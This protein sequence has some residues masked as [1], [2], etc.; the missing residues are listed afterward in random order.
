M[1]ACTGLLL[2]GFP[3]PLNRKLV[4]FV[5]PP[6]LSST[7]G[8]KSCELCRSL[9]R[10]S[11]VPPCGHVFCDVCYTQLMG[12]APELEPSCPVDNSFIRPEEVAVVECSENELGYVYCL[13]RTNGCSFTGTLMEALR[14]HFP[15]CEF[16]QVVC[17]RCGRRVL[18][19]SLVQHR[20]KCRALTLAEGQVEPTAEPP[21]SAENVSPASTSTT[22]LNDDQNPIRLLQSTI[23]ALRNDVQALVKSQLDTKSSTSMFNPQVMTA[24]AKRSEERLSELLDADR[25]VTDHFVPTPRVGAAS[26]DVPTTADM[27]RRLEVLEGRLSLVQLRVSKSKGFWNVVGYEAFKAEVDP[28][29]QIA[30]RFSHPMAISGYTVKFQVDIDMNEPPLAWLGLYAIFLKG[31]ADEYLDWPVKK[32]L[33]FTLVHPESARKNIRKHLLPPARRDLL[34]C[35]YRP[36]ESGFNEGCGFDRVAT[37]DTMEREGYVM[38]DSFTVAI[39]IRQTVPPVRMMD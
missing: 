5:Q 11:H 10:R 35:F 37:L 39:S 19:S 6:S 8:P 21:P 2:V 9:S 23:L 28:E 17:P 12:C 18:H 15:H 13:N 31:P 30:S 27:L 7:A 22:K 26:A 38:N 3:E 36:G 34:S 16:H 14:D 25:K 20:L 32:P 1:A 24:L 29:T 4:D 33:L